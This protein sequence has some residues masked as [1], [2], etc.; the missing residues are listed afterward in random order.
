MI[1]KSSGK[2]N[3]AP[4]SSGGIA[5]WDVG[6]LSYARTQFEL[7]ALHEHHSINDRS[8][9]QDYDRGP[10]PRCPRRRRTTPIRT[11]LVRCPLL[12]RQSDISLS[13]N[14]TDH[15]Y[16]NAQL[17]RALGVLYDRKGFLPF[18]RNRKAT[19]RELQFRPV[20]V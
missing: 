12:P 10:P 20:P 3:S 18:G 2:D 19:E 6:K 15:E 8:I 13:I 5:C 4:A 9:C 1:N 7:A 17:A 16:T 14:P 11:D